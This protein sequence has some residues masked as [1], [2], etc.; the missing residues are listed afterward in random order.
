MSAAI[1]AT[2]Q[3]R[4]VPMQ[5]GQIQRFPR[6]AWRDELAL[7]S[8]AG[9]DGIEWIHDEFAEGDNPLGQ[10]GGH[11]V[12]ATA[13]RDAGTRV[14][15]GCYD[16]VMNV[17]LWAERADWGPT[18]ARIAVVAGNLA[19]L[20]AGHL[21]LP[22]MRQVDIRDESVRQTAARFVREVVGVTK[23]HGLPV[24]LETALRSADLLRVLDLIGEGSCRA[25]FDTGNLVQFGYKPMDELLPLLPRIGS[26][27]IKDST[28]TG[29]TVP[30]GEGD[31]DFS[32]VI[33]ALLDSGYR[34]LWTVQGARR[35]GQPDFEVGREYAQF[36]RGFLAGATNS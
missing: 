18:L 24:H 36:L 14:L 28:P 34:G 2:T 31:V 23:A 13:V 22:L 30:L 12:L 26:V 9:Y 4:L 11:H 3:G 35:N 16:D 29:G 8:W 6:S 25:T 33:A 15:S 20:G 7:V 17:A 32:S 19:A 10:P 1:I 21:V 27:H 5:D